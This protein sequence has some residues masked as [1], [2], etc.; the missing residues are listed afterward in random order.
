MLHEVE[1]VLLLATNS[2]V[3]YGGGNT[4]NKALQLAHAM[5][6]DKLQGNVAR[7]TGPSIELKFLGRDLLF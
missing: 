6:R 7:I 1:P 2:D 3:A 5:L 4:G